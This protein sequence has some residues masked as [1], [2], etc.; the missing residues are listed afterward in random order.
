MSNTNEPKKRVLYPWLKKYQGKAYKCSLALIAEKQGFEKVIKG[1]IAFN[2]HL[3]MIVDKT[4]TI[5]P[6]MYKTIRKFYNK[7]GRELS[8]KEF[9]MIAV[10]RLTFMFKYEKE[11]KEVIRLPEHPFHAERLKTAVEFCERLIKS[12]KTYKVF[13]TETEPPTKVKTE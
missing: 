4:N 13:K 10:A 8:K 5:F 11:N 2:A 1:D 7:R 3:K 12:G 9:I 6:S